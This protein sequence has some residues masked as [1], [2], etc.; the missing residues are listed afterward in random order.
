MRFLRK[1]F[2]YTLRIILVLF[3]LVI[4]GMILLYIPAI[5]NFVKG[6][7][8]QYVNQNLDMK[9]SVGRI[10]LKFPLDLT[11]ENIYLGQTEKD[12]ML[13]ADV[14]QVN[15]AL[16]K[17]LKKEI[18]IRRLVVENVA[19]NLEDSLSGLKMNVGLKELNLH[20]DRLNFSQQEVEIPFVVFKGGNIRMN[21]GGESAVDT[22]G[23]GESNHWHFKVDEVVVDD[24]DYQLQGLPMGEFH[25][26]MGEALLKRVDVGLE[27][28]TIDLEKITLVRGFCDLLM[29][30]PTEKQNEIEVVTEESM[31][32]QIRVGTVELEDNRFLMKPMSVPVNAERFPETVRVSALSL[33]MDSVFNRGTEVAAIIQNLRFKEGNGLDLKDLSCRINLE[34]GQTNVSNLILKTSNSQLK[35]DVRAESG[36]SDFGIETPFQ[37][38]INGNIA[39]QDL[40]LFMP[41]FNNQL[42]N[43]LSDKVFSLS[44]LV[45]GNINQLNIAH[46]DIEAT[47]GFSL[48]SGGDVAFVTDM[49]KVVGKLNI[50]FIVDRGA[51]FL[52]LLSKNGVAGLVVPDHLSL[53]TDVVIANQTAKVD[54]EVKPGGG[55]LHTV[56]NYDWNEETYRAEIHLKD[57]ALNKFMPNDSLGVITANLFASGRGVDWKEMVA[58]VDFELV[59]LFYNGYDYKNV[60]LD[61]TLKNREVTGALLSDNQ[62]LDLGMK[63]RLWSDDNGYKINLNGDVKNV[64]LKGLH[65]IQRDM[66]FSLGLNVDAEL[67]TDSTSSL[68][69]DFSNI[70]LRDIVTRK[71]GDLGVTFSGLCDKTLLNVKAG[72]LLLKFE[73]D[74]GSNTLIDRFSA[75]GDLLVDQVEKHDFNMEKLN[76]LLPDFR[77]TVGASRENLLNGYLKN[78]GICFERMTIDIGTDISHDFGLTSKVYGLNIDGIVL[79]SLFVYTKQ[80]N[81]ALHYGVDV[82][83]AKNQ[84]EGLAQLTVEGNVEY[85]QINVRIREHANEE[86]EIFNI[87]ANIALQD[88]VFS[89]SISPDPLILGYVSWQINRGNFIR[90][91]QG[92]IPAA[93]LQL[94]D[95]DRRIRLISE[96]NANHEPESLIVDI[97]GIDLGG[98]SKTLSFIPDISGLLG[99]DVQMYSKN[100]V[101]DINGTVSV[102]DFYYRKEHVG[103]LGLGIKYRL[104]QQTEHDVDFSLSV[105]GVKA[106][107]TKGKLETGVEDKNIALDIDIPRFPLR[108]AGVFT[109][110]GIM[111]LGGDMVGALQVKGQIDH[112]LINGNLRFRDGIIEALMIG[113]SFKIDSSTIVIH[114]N[115]LD[116]NHF[117]LIAPNKQRLELLGTVDFAS[118]SAIKMDASIQAKNFQAMKVKENTETMVYGKL[119]VDLSATLKGMLDNLKVRGNINLLDN[120]EVYYTLKSSPLEL[121][122]RSADVVRFVSFS[123][124]TQLVAADELQ[125][126][127]SVNL[128]LLMS[129]NIA[130]LVGLNVLL[131]SN[132]QNRVA[133]N[134]GGSLTYTLNPVG[135]TRLVGRYVLTSGVVSYGLPVIGQKDFK[136]QDGSFVEWTGDLAN[137]TLNITAAETISA[138]VTDDSQK[139]RLVTFNAIIK[140]SNTLEKLD[141]TFDLA[142]EGDITIQNQLAAMTAEER[143]KEAMNMMIYGTYSGLG[144]VAKS[145]ASDNALNNFVEN[146]LNQWSR[147]HLKNMDLT[148]GINTYNQVSEAGESKKT[149]Y[150]Y[151]F[152][153]R[154]FNNKVRVK[155]GGRI[156]TDNDPAAGGVEESLVDDIAIEYVFGKNPNFFL[157]IFRH[158]GY[159][160]VLEGE[161]T[162]TGIGVVLRKNFQKFM[163]IFRRKKKVQVEPQKEPIENEESGK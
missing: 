106:L 144:T 60:I 36:I 130:P 126:V 133:I 150:S 47:D 20:V 13:Y 153:K 9:L 120:S 32:W 14:I 128:D 22:T 127:S 78:S 151:Q 142:A 79:D 37:L 139:S 148:F 41:N 102:D 38:S 149:D 12:T 86:G 94:L 115:L 33:K 73:G 65:F 158:T 119:F 85:D 25:A 136:I 122:D 145:S 113:T 57:F 109:P 44:S 70:V 10:L 157:K 45:K 49:E 43:W 56:A 19:V 42:N 3:A 15:I 80:K 114:D 143:S 147:K 24:I 161:V 64:D 96:E 26:G 59:S 29:A 21:L 95:G 50:A 101:I 129:V 75:A 111:N 52:P 53:V 46:F 82:F 93:N 160:S 105:D 35:M 118:F 83:G 104:S 66:A 110:P 67:K 108:L 6:K 159:E 54:M 125:Q 62:E 27:K 92:E 40:L 89:V 87:G 124:T 51:Y 5:Q 55:M 163:D 77:L 131:S 134:G 30:E 4:F 74:G 69:A 34:S 112:P 8:E 28:Q 61:A 91:K 48:K 154:L 23:G 123:D 71:L 81:V 72:D 146:E 18:E 140:I 11:V 137:P 121:T 39:G 99:V 2:K 76:E 90:L 58:K 88:S 16:M 98:L 1:L 135:E 17:L 97:K 156:S 68:R 138:S 117:G 100:E 132:G 116:F 162:Q 103:D 31:P 7:A 84:L 141:I 107:L 152:S 63:F 155:V